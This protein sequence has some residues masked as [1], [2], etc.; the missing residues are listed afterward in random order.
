MLQEQSND[1]LVLHAFFLQHKMLALLENP[2]FRQNILRV[3]ALLTDRIIHPLEEA[4]HFLSKAMR[5]DDKMRDYRSYLQ[6]YGAQL[7]YAT[8]HYFDHIILVS[9]AIRLLQ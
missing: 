7:C 1:L 4:A 2:P 5:M 3:K 8:F 6:P 9:L